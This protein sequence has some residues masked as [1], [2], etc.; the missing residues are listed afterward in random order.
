MWMPQATGCP[1]GHS[2]VSVKDARLEG[3]LRQIKHTLCRRTPQLHKYSK[4]L[5]QNETII[6]TDRDRLVEK[7]NRRAQICQVRAQTIL[8]HR[9]ILISLGQTRE[10][11][12]VAREFAL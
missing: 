2:V 1:Q 4:F 11:G 3:E 9:L 7:V 6:K 8:L 5:S 12:G 10:K